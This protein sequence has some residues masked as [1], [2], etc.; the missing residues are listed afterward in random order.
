MIQGLRVGELPVKIRACGDIRVRVYQSEQD[1]KPVAC[2]APTHLVGVGGKPGALNIWHDTR[3]PLNAVASVFHRMGTQLPDGEEEE[4]LYF[5][6]F[7]ERVIPAVFKPVHEVPSFE[8][9]LAHTSYSGAEKDKLRKDLGDWEAHGISPKDRTDLLF[10]KWESYADVGASRNIIGP[11][12]RV[13]AALG[14]ISH[15]ID[16]ATFEAPYFVKKIDVRE[17]PKLL[18]DTFGERPVAMSDF[19]SMEA[20]HRG[21]YMKVLLFW[22]DHMV[23]NLP[24]SAEK[25][26]LRAMFS[27][28]RKASGQGITVDYDDRL[29]SGRPW[30]SSANSVLN[31]LIMEYLALRSV[32]P[33]LEPEVL[34]EMLV[35]GKFEGDDGIV[36]SKPF[37]DRII[38]RMGLMLKVE[39]HAHYGQGSFCGVVAEPGRNTTI[40]DPTKVLL[41]FGVMPAKYRHMKA[42]KWKAYLRCKA[43]SYAH[44]YPNCPVVSAYARHILRA[45]RSVDVRSAM[46]QFDM[47]HRDKIV[48]ALAALVHKE[49]PQ[50]INQIERD[51]VAERWGISVETQM[52]FEAWFDAND[53]LRPF[54]DF[55]LNLKGVNKQFA[56][57]YVVSPGGRP[58]AYKRA[59]SGLEWMLAH[60]RPSARALI[61]LDQ[62]ELPVD[63]VPSTLVGT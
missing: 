35:P 33:E 49:K 24:E 21:V 12:A 25:R 51:I 6:R 18:H 14:P 8:E 31:F 27:G 54:P 39:Y 58:A 1:P 47:W 46:Y 55:G 37:N 9:W 41:N 11:S 2:V 23:Q 26:T 48:K 38:A 3:D 7:A 60:Q 16:E 4:L 32:H 56:E 29:P 63:C 10:T 42:G 61:P 44:Q 40:C 43:L 5:R 50:P 20:H 52:L 36:E 17:R 62:L 28:K 59:C 30:T 45:T 13:K 53:E 34:A 57:D 22:I 19:S 15:A